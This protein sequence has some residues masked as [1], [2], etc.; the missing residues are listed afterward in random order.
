M[1]GFLHRLAWRTWTIGQRMGLDLRPRHFYSEL[2]SIP[3]LARTRNWRA[4][5]PM[6]SLTGANRKDQVAWIENLVAHLPDDDRA[7]SLTHARACTA[8]GHDG[9]G[10]IEAAVLDGFVRAHQPRRM[11]QI[12]GGV[13]SAVVRH[14]A[15]SVDLDLELI[16][17]EPTPD[18]WLEGQHQA[19]GLTLICEPAERLDVSTLAALGPN[20]LLFVDSTHAVRPGGEVN[21][22]VF[23]VLD[24]LPRNCWI[25]FHDITFPYDYPRSALSGEFFFHHESVLL[26]AFLMHNAQFSMEASLSLLHHECPDDLARALPFYRP[27]RGEDG[28]QD[29][30]TDGHFPTSLWM[31]RRA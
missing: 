20:D 25:H 13:S 3:H 1:R 15:R 18:A 10:P 16:V 26:Q 31:R 9:F 27:A 23:E 21:L 5:R 24:A 6:S 14:A 28:L 2:P 29:R 12:G 8:V 22:I 11:I 19:G 4:P 7:R 17:V 30:G